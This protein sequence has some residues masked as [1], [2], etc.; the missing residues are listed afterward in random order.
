MC[1]GCMPGTEVLKNPQPKLW[2]PPSPPKWFRGSHPTRVPPTEA[3]AVRGG[4][5]RFLGKPKLF[6]D[7]R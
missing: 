1:R 4:L 7:R 2:I 6:G 3:E 5:F